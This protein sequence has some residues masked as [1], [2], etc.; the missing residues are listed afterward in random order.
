MN[1][2]S[3]AILGIALF[4]GLV[5]A[6]YIVSSGILELKKMERTVSLASAKW[7]RMSPCGPSNTCVLAMI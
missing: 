3:A 4:L 2:A 1:K 6:G 5:G 7:K